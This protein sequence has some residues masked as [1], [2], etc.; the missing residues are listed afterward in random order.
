MTMLFTDRIPAR[1]FGI[2]SVS[3]V[4]GFRK[5]T[6]KTALSRLSRTIPVDAAH[7]FDPAFFAQIRLWWEWHNTREPLAV[8]GPAGCGKT[9]GVLQFLARVNAPVVTLTCRRRMDKY[10]LIGRWGP[11]ED[12][13][14]TWYDGPAALAWRHGFVLVV[15]ELTAAPA[16]VW[17]S[18]N[19]LLEGDDLVNDRTGEVIPRHANT[20]VILTDNCRLGSTTG[21]TGYVAR[22]DQD[23]SVFERCWHIALSFP[24]AETELAMLAKKTAASL[25]GL[26]AERTDALL[27]ASV[28]FA[29]KTREAQLEAKGRIK[30][31]AVSPRTLLR[32]TE[33]MGALM[34]AGNTAQAA[35]TTALDLSLAAG[36]SPQNRGHLQHWAAWVFSD[37]V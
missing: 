29:R 9:T 4:L 19:D 32:F 20:R 3:T 31:A 33:L 7:T 2:D 37:L 5:T 15:N 6:R 36:C 16:D 35:L 22:N 27:R 12:G 14:L 23:R 25:T 24:D 21:D 8:T 34:L 28:A 11:G 17:V 26:D 1:T 10:E 18:M 13:S 30:P